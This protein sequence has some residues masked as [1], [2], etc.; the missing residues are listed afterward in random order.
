MAGSQDMAFWV[1]L[2]V[3]STSENFVE[4]MQFEVTFWSFIV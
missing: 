3:A 2:L 4:E 1:G